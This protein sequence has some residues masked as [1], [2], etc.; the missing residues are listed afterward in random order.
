MSS[1]RK[2]QGVCQLSRRFRGCVIFPEDSG[3]VSSFQKIQG[4]CHLSRRFRGC[5]NFPEDSG[6]VS[7]FQKIHTILEGKLWIKF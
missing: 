6:G 3:G 4:V 2:I 1:F 7:T 5:V